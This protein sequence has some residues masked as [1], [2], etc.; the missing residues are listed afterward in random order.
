M[1]H[2]NPYG[3][4]THLDFLLMAREDVKCLDAIIERRRSVQ[5]RFTAFLMQ[6]AVEKLLKALLTYDGESAGYMYP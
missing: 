6:Q 3:S 2:N 1:A 4:P 5:V